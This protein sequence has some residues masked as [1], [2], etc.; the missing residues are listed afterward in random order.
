MGGT[1]NQFNAF[2]IEI[3]IGQCSTIQMKAVQ[4]G[5][6]HNSAVN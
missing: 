4:A 3:P 1:E 2:K 5:A 6:H